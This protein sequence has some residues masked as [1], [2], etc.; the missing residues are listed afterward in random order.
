MAPAVGEHSRT[1]EAIDLMNITH[2][3]IYL[4]PVKIQVIG[5]H[6][7]MLTPTAIIG[8]LSR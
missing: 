3:I 4:W 6:I 2:R 8:R 5:Y 1:V 7:F